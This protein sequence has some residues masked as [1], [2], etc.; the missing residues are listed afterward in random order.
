M[1]KINYLLIV[2][3]SFSLLFS[4]CGSLNNTSKGALFGAGG[5]AAIGAVVGGLIGKDGKSAAIGAAIGGAVGGTTGAIIGKKMDKAAEE[6]KALEGAK[7]E[8]FEDANGL[9]AVKVTF[10]SGILFGF[11]STTLSPASKES[12][13]KF[14]Q[15]LM[16]NPTM[17]IAIYGH[18]DNVGT[19]EINQKVSQKRAD[20]V[21]EYLKK[22]GVKYSQFKTVEGLNFSQPIASND[23]KAGQTANR[24]VE[25]FMYASEKMVKEAEK[26]ADTI[27]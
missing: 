17:D 21:A 24:R 3:L 2:T 10:D 22:E 26:E 7:V 8:T 16:K 5:G 12:L 6:A 11:N 25:V 19:K 15:I 4:S 23:T 18:T 14:A 9:K 27:K 13:T 20:R 1:K